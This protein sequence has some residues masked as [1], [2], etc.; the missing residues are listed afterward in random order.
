MTDFPSYPI[1]PLDSGSPDQH[2]RQIARAAN[3]AV[4]GKTN[5]VGEV[6]LNESATTTTLT[7]DRL[8]YFSAVVWEPVTANAASELAAGTLYVTLANR[9][10][11]EYTI[12]HAS[13]TSTDRTFRYAIIG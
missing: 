10:N 1:A 4:S 8:T 13:A 7:D 11:G 12:S 2:R 6:T 3:G 5:N 9:N